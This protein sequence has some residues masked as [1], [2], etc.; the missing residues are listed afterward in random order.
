MQIVYV[1]EVIDPVE[2]HHGARYVRRFTYET[3]EEAWARYG[4]AIRFGFEAYV[5]GV[6]RFRGARTSP[7]GHVATSSSAHASHVPRDGVGRARPRTGQ[8]RNPAGGDA[9]S[10]PGPTSRQPSPL[11]RSSWR[12]D[13][14]RDSRP[15]DLGLDAP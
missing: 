1:M 8:G 3:R 14:A 9:L 4:V 5:E 10:L 12:C 15:R 7:H 13:L 6:R 2:R 11:T